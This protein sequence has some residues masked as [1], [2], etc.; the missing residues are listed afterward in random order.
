M[1]DGVIESSLDVAYD[2]AR[3]LTQG[4]AGYCNFRL[5]SI[6]A[7]AP[8]SGSS[9]HDSLNGSMQSALSAWSSLLESDARAIEQTGLTF[10]GLDS[11]FAKSLLGLGAG[12]DVSW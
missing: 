6:S 4:L 7:S 1:G 9:T 8:V 2:E 5:K 11:L 12:D 10:E 3:A